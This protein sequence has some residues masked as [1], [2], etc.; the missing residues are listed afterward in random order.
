M[1]AKEAMDVSCLVIHGSPM[2]HEFP[3]MVHEMATMNHEC[4]LMT[5]QSEAIEQ[6]TPQKKTLMVISKRSLSKCRKQD[7]ALDF[8]RQ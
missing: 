6:L 5:G 2:F 4:K 1:D 7:V 8:H 3:F